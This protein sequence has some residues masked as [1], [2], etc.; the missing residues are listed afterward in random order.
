MCWI[1]YTTF[2]H[3]GSYDG[4][5]SDIIHLCLLHW[6][7]RSKAVDHWGWREALLVLWED[8]GTEGNCNKLGM[9]TAAVQSRNTVYPNTKHDKYILSFFSGK[10]HG[11][12]L[13]GHMFDTAFGYWREITHFFQACTFCTFTFWGRQPETRPSVMKGS[14]FLSCLAVRQWLCFKC[15]FSTHLNLN[16][17]SCLK[18]VQCCFV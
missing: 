18:A 10:S 6:I 5:L 8:D 13:Y 3:N 7:S 2:L 15:F 16:I 17:L 1:I 9:S 14:G 12:R 4:L 11:N